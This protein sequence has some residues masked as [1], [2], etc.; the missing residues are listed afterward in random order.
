[1]IPIVHCA[2]MAYPPASLFHDSEPDAMR[3]YDL[4]RPG[5]DFAAAAQAAEPI[6]GRWITDD[7][8]AIVTISQCGKVVCGRI[9]QNPGPNPER[10]AGRR[11]QPR[12][13]VAT[14]PDPG[15]GGAERLHRSG[16]GLAR[17]DLRSGSRQMVQ[18]DRR[19]RTGRTEREGLHPVLLSRAALEAGAVT[20]RPALHL[21][22]TYRRRVN[23]SLARIW[24]NVFDWEHLAHL[25]DGSFAECALLDRGPW[26]WRVALTPV[27]GATQEIEMRADRASGRYTSTTIAGAGAGSEI[28]VALTHVT[29][30]QVDVVVEFHL[31]ETA[32]TVWQRSAKP[33]PPLTPGCGTRTRR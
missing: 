3:L 13:Q 17:S 16:Q 9:T 28:R 7:G 33:M 31:P 2:F 14:P 21:A 20:G 6:T 29:S 19:A 1:M 23:A 10:P 24:E 5:C 8:K 26:G 18:V 12:P 22:G 4:P 25:H 27:G 32:P 15:T 30:E 11:T